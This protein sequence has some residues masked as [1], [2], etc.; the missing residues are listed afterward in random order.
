[1]TPAEH[2]AF[3]EAVV[4]RL[5][6]DPDVLGV[7]G[8]GST[9]GLPPEPDGFSDHDLFVVTRSGAQER[10]RQDLGW[11]PGTAGPV[12][13]AFRETAHGV[14]AL[15]AGGHLVEFAAFDLDELALAR[16]NRYA[17]LLD[18][19]DVAARLGRVREATATAVAAQRVDEA[20]Q[21]GQFLTTLVVGS[22]RA[23]RGERLSGHQLVRVA[24]LGHL[25][26]LLRSALP[27]AAA[28]GLDDLDPY[29]RLERALP[30]AARRLD[31]AL[32]LPV[33]PA[34]R[35]LL[36]LLLRLRPGLVAPEALGAVERALE[37]AA[38]G[39]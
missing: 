3:T 26:T 6:H 12:A 27:P 4:R 30:E 37:R 33:V 14:K 34:A 23:A 32:R 7:V 20:W 28:A 9:S 11:L 19:A 5:A 24:A 29:R 35:A 22:S 10:F 13:L 2:R 38:G 16:V 8:L 17:V 18:R 15:L 31:E 21:L 25:V 36:G 39:P 1:M